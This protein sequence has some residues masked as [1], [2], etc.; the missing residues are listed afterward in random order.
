MVGQNPNILIITLNISGLS[1]KT[2]IVRTNLLKS[3]ISMLSTKT[4][5]KYREDTNK[6][7]II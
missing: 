2:G 4:H 3:P 6:E 1:L 5:F 7:K